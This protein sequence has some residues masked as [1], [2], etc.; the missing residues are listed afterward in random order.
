MNECHAQLM[1]TNKAQ[2]GMLADMPKLFVSFADLAELQTKERKLT[3]ILPSHINN[4]SRI[5]VP[6]QNVLYG[7]IPTIN[8]DESTNNSNNMYIH[9]IN[10]TVEVATSKAK[11][12]TMIIN[13]ICGKQIKYLVKQEKNGDLRKDSRLM[14]FNNVI[15][16]IM[17]TNNHET[18]SRMLKVRTYA[19]I[20]MNEECGILEWVNNT[21]C[22]R[23]LIAESINYWNHSTNN[24]DNN[25]NNNENNITTNMNTNTIYSIINFK[26]IFQPF[27]DLQKNYETD[28]NNLV[29][30]YRQLILNH[31]KP[32]LSRWFYEHFNDPT[33]WY[34]SRVLFTRSVAIWSVVGYII[35][36]GDRH[37]ENILI[38]TTNG[39]CIHVDFDCL[40]DKGLTLARP[41]IIPFRLTPN[42][43]DAMGMT[44]VEGIYR[45]TME[46]VM[47]LL[48]DNKDIL[49]SILEP[50]LR[51]PTV[52]WGRSGR[53][54]QRISNDI[55]Q[56][57]SNSISI[58]LHQDHENA[59]AKE[60]LYKI[61][62]RL[63]GVY[64][65]THPY[66]E[67][68]KNAYNSRK[69]TVPEKG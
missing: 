19:V 13:T 21:T 40:F 11:P 42:M 57:K 64:N 46:I 5:L 61:S 58:G 38:D 34:E 18:T 43:V 29:I 54:Q 30:K 63:D 48:K 41:E 50:F 1:I 60:T 23:H 69:E 51:D 39:E 6:T 14:E 59:D 66:A 53:Q 20:C 15:N 12:K 4:V 68:I 45:K 55:D 52:A 8:T 2:A 27:C 67:R 3:Y 47:S 32:C 10:E 28:I 65:I 25:N 33:L 31:N 24:N 36:L 26:E 44:G 49:M 62:R 16:R 9:S 37:T 22:I 35:G 56:T 17:S 7:L